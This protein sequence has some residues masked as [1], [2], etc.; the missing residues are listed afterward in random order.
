M[1]RFTET[2]KWDDPW[3]RELSVGTK[4][5]YLWLLDHCDIAG[6]V[7]PDLGL[8]SFQ[9]GQPVNEQN[10][11]DLGDRLKSLERGKF[12]VVKFVRFQFGSISQTSLVHR[13][14]IKTLESHGLPIP[15][16]LPRDSQGMDMGSPCP[17][18]KIKRKEK[19]KDG[20]CEGKDYHKDSR[21]V[22]WFLNETVNKK[23]RETDPNLSIISARLNEKGVDFEGC[24]AMIVRQHK[25]WKNTEYQDYLQPSTLFQASKFDGYYTARNEPVIKNENNGASGAKGF[26]R[27]KGT[28]NEGRAESYNI[29]AIEAKRKVR[30]AKQPELGENA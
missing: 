12:L 28:L 1:K 19:E 26:D 9:I 18:R 13:S 22:L 10:I 30:D 11:S 5:L 16:S 17:K 24:K 4:L 23:F 3:F 21:S 25:K 27:N 15:I 14:V 2:T 7:H 29:E 20:E 8:A 6:V